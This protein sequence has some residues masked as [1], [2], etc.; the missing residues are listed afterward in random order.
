MIVKK[1]VCVHI[2]LPQLQQQQQLLFV[3]MLMSHFMLQG[4]EM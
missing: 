4:L 3:A 2:P 1:I